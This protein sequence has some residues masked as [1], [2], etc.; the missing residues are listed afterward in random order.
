MKWEWNFNYQYW[1]Y[2]E[3]VNATT[4]EAT[5]TYT[6]NAYSVSLKSYNAAGC[7]KRV[8][9]QIN[10]QPPVADIYRLGDNPYG[11]RVDCDPATI[12]FKATSLA[13]LAKY[14]WTFDIATAT[15]TEAEPTYTFSGPGYHQL[16]LDFE[17]DKGCKGEAF[18]YYDISVR[19]K[20]V[21][22]FESV[23]PTTVCGNTKAIFKST[24]TGSSSTAEV[25]KVNGVFAN[26]SYYNTFEWQFSEKGKHTIQLIAGAIGCQDTM[27]KV[28]YID[29]L[30]PFPK[31][32]RYEYSCD[33]RSKVTVFHNSR[34]A[35]KT[36][37]DFGDGNTGNAQD[38]NTTHTYPLPGN[39]N[40]TLLMKD[41]NG[42]ISTVSMYDKVIIH[43]NPVIQVSPGLG[44]LCVGQPI[45]LTASGAATY[46]WTPATGL[47]DPQSDR[48]MASPIQT[49][50]YQVEGI[51]VHGCKNTKAYV[52]TVHQPFILQLAPEAALC[53]G[54]ATTLQASG[55]DKYKWINNTTG[56]A[57]TLAGTTQATPPATSIY[58]VVG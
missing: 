55:A 9:K 40:P 41:V 47:N 35:E 13:T 31:I 2:P 48:P 53:V 28:D 21:A 1:Q 50:T 56:L 49:T 3:I 30:P 44:S 33:D 4:K 39:Y 5:H 15:S 25:W 16:R 12:S 51:D 6:P 27:T 24:G 14:K 20:P 46:T 57:N 23:T 38:G 7:S 26:T 42:C 32:I 58:T 37:W 19:T 22:N 45:Q 29:V 52:L 8:I 36:I 18:Y 34:Y 11:Q 43:P 54:N 10:L 17:T